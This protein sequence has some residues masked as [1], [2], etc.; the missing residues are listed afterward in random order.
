M[1]KSICVLF[2]LLIWAAAVSL[3]SASTGVFF[4]FS[5]SALPYTSNGMTISKVLS[6]SP[7]SI[8]RYRQVLQETLYADASSQAVDIRAQLANGGT[9]DM[10]LI[11]VLGISGT[12]TVQSSK[13]S[14]G[15]MSAP[16]GYIFNDDH[17]SAPDWQGITYFDLIH[18]PAS[19]SSTINIDSITFTPV[20]EP[21]T[22]TLLALG[23]V[24]LA[25]MQ[26]R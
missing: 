5:D 1:L 24:G 23:V 18:N 16:G 10:N 6:D 4:G 3:A 25:V 22:L 14:A 7:A 21:S 13:G 19:P 8:A 20:P 11:D 2:G 17:F 9:F 15:H 12:W 26:R